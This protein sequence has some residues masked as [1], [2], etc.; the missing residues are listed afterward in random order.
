MVNQQILDYIKQQTLQGI[1]REQI[2]SSLMSNGWQASD[3]DEGFNIIVPTISGIPVAPTINPV[4]TMN[5]VNPTISYAGFWLRVVASF[6]DGFILNLVYVIVAFIFFWFFAK[7]NSSLSNSTQTIMSILYFFIWILY[8]PLME[9]RSGATLGKKIIGIKVLNVNGEPI[10]FLKSVGRNLAKIISVLILMIG[11]MMAGFTK[12]KQGLHDIIASCVVVKSREVSAGK[13]W[14]VII[15]II[16]ACIATVVIAVTQFFFIISFALS[17]LFS[18]GMNIPLTP[19][20]KSS[21]TQTSNDGSDT[22]AS[23][24]S[25]ATPLSS[26]E[27]DAYFSKPITGLDSESDYSGPHTYAGPALIAFDDFWGLNCALPFV[28]ILEDN[29]DYVWVYLTSVTSKSGKEILDKESSFEKDIFFKGLRLS[30]ETQPFEFLSDNRSVHLISGS[31]LTDAKIIKGT[32]F[33]KVPLNTNKN[34]FYEKSYPFVVNISS[35]IDAPVSSVTSQQSGNNNPAQTQTTAKGPKEVYVEFINRIQQAKT[36]L[37]AMNITM[38]YGYFATPAEKAKV[39]ASVVEQMNSLSDTEKASQL[40]MMK[41]FMKIPT[42]AEVTETIS[43]NTA[44]V[45]I[46]DSDGVTG[47]TNMEKHGSVWTLKNE[48]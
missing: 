29:K 28:S 33:F 21:F 43:G 34:N 7:N 45:K 1:S 10:G 6:I 19:G 41:S 4:S 13:I 2:K 20:D 9:S 40:T 12:K 5:S 23:S 46:T 38:E 42:S 8:F 37:D 27:Y 39:I 3:I 35:S 31:E 15:L 30:K 14:A 11:F 26:A 16:V 25:I 22:S 32:L 47:S 36:L 24:D 48:N 17:S 18:G 44:V